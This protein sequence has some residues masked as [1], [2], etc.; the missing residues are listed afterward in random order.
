MCNT[1]GKTHCSGALNYEFVL[2][3]EELG[4]FFW[5]A[6]SLLP[7]SG[8]CVI[9]LLPYTGHK[10]I[11]ISNISQWKSTSTFLTFCNMKSVTCP[12]PG[13]IMITRP[14]WGMVNVPNCTFWG[15]MRVPWVQYFG[16]CK[17]M[18]HSSMKLTWYAVKAYHT[19]RCRNNFLRHFLEENSVWS[20]YK[21][22]HFAN[23]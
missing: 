22:I 20:G 8:L 23:I 11:Q 14:H 13:T 12:W 1:G 18:N 9:T 19:V 2:L 6:L 15:M 10:Y 17:N 4:N 16:S 7:C 3:L 5:A 21:T